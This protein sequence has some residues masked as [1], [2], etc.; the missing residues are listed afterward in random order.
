M[1]EEKEASAVA[2]D[3]AA[4]EPP[5]SQL[6]IFKNRIHLLRDSNT[7]D[8]VAWVSL[9]SS[10]EETSASDIEVISSVYCSFLL[11]FPLCYG[12]WIKYAAHKARFCTY[13]DVVEVYEQAVQAV[14]HSVDLWVS[15][16]G[17]GICAYEDPAHI[18]R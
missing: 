13:E 2:S 6:D 7:G 15:Y 11:E 3:P 14:P 5:P 8:F 4:P 17:F 18:R 9:I 10:A 1:V 16:C 12:Y